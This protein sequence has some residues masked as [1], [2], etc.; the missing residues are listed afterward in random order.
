M[1]IFCL[2]GKY[3][4]K[5]LTNKLLH[6][7]GTLLSYNKQ[8]KFKGFWDGYEDKINDYC[9]RNF[10]QEKNVKSDLSK[11][12]ESFQQKSKIS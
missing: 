5:S 11:L 6:P 7:V 3:Y 10:Y 12:N 9:S 1:I 2:F 8:W 4:P